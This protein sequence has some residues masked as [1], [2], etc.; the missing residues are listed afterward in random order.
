MAV[1][2][3]VGACYLS[4]AGFALLAMGAVCLAVPT[5]ADRLWWW[6]VATYVVTCILGVLLGATANPATILA[7][8]LMLYPFVLLKLFCES[9]KNK[10]VYKADQDVE[11]LFGF[12]EKIE[13]TSQTLV[14]PRLSGTP[15]WIVYYVFWNVTLTIFSMLFCLFVPTFLQNPNALWLG[16]G[17]VVLANVFLPFYSKLL[18]ATFGLV[19]KHLKK[20]L[21]K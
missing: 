10:V 5:L 11:Q 9:P 4:W 17:L 18:D 16:I 19:G 13:K 6:S 20:Y 21:Q 7:G 14:V 12:D 2:C 1:I 15:R 8:V 3:T